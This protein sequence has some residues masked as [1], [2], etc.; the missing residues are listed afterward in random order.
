[1]DEGRRIYNEIVAPTAKKQ[2]GNIDC[3]LLE[4][5]DEP[6]EGI[7]YNSWKTKEDADA[8]ETSGVYHELTSKI[9]HTM[10]RQP[11][12]KQYKVTVLPQR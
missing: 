6:G 8:Y 9:I 3:F 10:V 7:S 12:L 2:K 4:S 5:V 11:R 1:M